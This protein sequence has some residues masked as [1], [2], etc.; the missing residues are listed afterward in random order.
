MYTAV[1]EVSDTSGQKHVIQQQAIAIG[2]G[3]NY[4]KLEQNPVITSDMIPEG[5]SRID[6]RDPK[7][8]KEEDTYFALIANRSK[9]G[10]QALLYSSRDIRH[11]TFVSVFDK[12]EEKYGEMWECPD[13]F[14]LDG[15]EILLVCP[16]FMQAKG[17]EFHNGNNAVY[18]VGK[19]DAE[20]KHFIRAEA[21]QIDYGT[22]FYAPQT[23]MTPDGRRILLGWMQ[24]W[25]NRICPDDFDWCGMMT[26]PREL[27]LRDGCLIQTPIR[28]LLN[29]RTHKMEYLKLNLS[30]DAGDMEW[31]G[32]RGRCIDLIVTF[33]SR[34]CLEF[35]IKLASDGKGTETNLVLDVVK[36]ILSLDR[37]YSG[38]KQDILTDRSMYMNTNRE[39]L[40]LRILMDYYCIEVFANGGKE[41]M[42][43]LIYTPLEADG[44][45]FSCK[46]KTKL[47]IEKYDIEIKK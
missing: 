31:E 27:S 13:F 1:S 11:W 45:V 19:R 2:D 30:E 3:E 20:L 36:G 7:I 41:V 35:K 24:N 14:S 16:Q 25:V 34:D 12:S 5:C 37:T 26:V 44:I 40:E 47:T 22:D 28:E 39:T 15:Q 9:G 6:F 23:M 21:K 32:I 43:M 4:Q 38:M 18:F 8:W 46:G 10:G 29:Y 17:L 33:T 42:S